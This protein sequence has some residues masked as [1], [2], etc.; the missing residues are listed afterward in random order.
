[1]RATLAGEKGYKRFLRDSYLTVREG[2]RDST[3][4]ASVSG[5]AVGVYS[6]GGG[7]ATL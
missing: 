2:V 7:V 1:M 4:D 6:R 5:L 3:G